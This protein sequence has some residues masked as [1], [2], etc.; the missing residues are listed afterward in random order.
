[1]GALCT[2][3]DPV[4][5]MTPEEREEL[6]LK[7][8]FSRFDKD[9]S[10]VISK[11]NLKQLIQDDKT[12]GDADVDHILNKFGDD[13]QLSYEQF[14][15]WWNSTYTSYNDDNIKQILEDLHNEGAIEPP[16]ISPPRD[17]LMVDPKT[18]KR[19]S[20]MLMAETSAKSS[21]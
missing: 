5:E 9:N 14:K 16:T 13:E 6:K 10:G 11:E 2:K 20:Q 12:F 19:K 15:F 21:S 7:T 1:M 8:I 3:A 18:Q 17:D 4:E